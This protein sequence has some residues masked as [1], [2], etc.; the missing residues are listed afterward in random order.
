MS[1]KTKKIIV[2]SLTFSR[3]LGTFLMPIF[4]TFFNS[5]IFLVIVG[6]LLLTDFFDGM[7]AKHW[8]V[9]T[10]FGSLL[11][12]LADKMLAFSILIIL[13]LMY[14]FMFIPLGF[15]IL[16]TII[17]IKS[18]FLGIVTKSSEIGRIKM[19]ILGLSIFVLLLTGLCM[20]LKDI[21]LKFDIFEIIINNTQQI[22]DIAIS[23]AIV[24]EFIVACD[25]FIRLIKKNKK[26][27][28][29]NVL[30]FKKIFENITYVKEVLFDEE[31]YFMT[32]DK[33]LYEKLMPSKIEI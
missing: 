17:N 23:S 3:V 14:P 21:L 1:K 7:F 9:C 25:Y 10:I 6:L 13:G 20:E 27:N 22:V 31:Y 33:P 32:L 28:N 30:N 24:A 16:I 26:N 12:M 2:N 5:Y 11:D 15:E 19:W 4:Y 8:K 18:A 29:M